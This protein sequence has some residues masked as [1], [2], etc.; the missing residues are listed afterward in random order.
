[1]LRFFG[2]DRSQSSDYVERN[3]AAARALKYSFNPGGAEVRIQISKAHF[4]QRLKERSRGLVMHAE[5]VFL[6]IRT[7][8]GASNK[9]RL[10]SIYLARFGGAGG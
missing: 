1:M 8:R 3:E 7:N 6:P 9:N 2:S 10:P 5:P 4:K